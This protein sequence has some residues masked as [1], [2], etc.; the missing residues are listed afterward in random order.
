EYVGQLV[1]RPGGRTDVRIIAD[2]CL[3]C[4]IEFELGALGLSAALAGPFEPAR[5]FAKPRPN[6]A[7]A[8]GALLLLAQFPV[9]L[10]QRAAVGGSREV[11]RQS[12]LALAQPDFASKWLEAFGFSSHTAVQMLAQLGK[13]SLLPELGLGAT[14]TTIA[15]TLTFTTADQRTVS[16]VDIDAER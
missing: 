9:L 14:P 11:V 3:L 10:S 5:D 1:A 6:R 2:G 4:D 12:L 13:P 8:S 15:H 16:L 7:L